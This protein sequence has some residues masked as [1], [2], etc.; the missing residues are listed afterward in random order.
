MPYE[1]AYILPMSVLALFGAVV[2]FLLFTIKKEKLVK[3]IVQH[4]KLE[5]DVFLIFLA[6]LCANA[7]FLFDISFLGFVSAVLYLAA[8]VRMLSRFLRW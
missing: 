1:A 7:Y 3:V 8:A 4:R 5:R 6:S 2:S